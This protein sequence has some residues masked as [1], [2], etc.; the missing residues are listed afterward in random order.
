MKLNLKK[1]NFVYFDVYYPVTDT[2][3]GPSNLLN[4]EGAIRPVLS[5]VNVY[6]F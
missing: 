6:L 1:Y 4:S 3:K 2:D 5:I